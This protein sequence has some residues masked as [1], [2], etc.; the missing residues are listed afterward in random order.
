MTGERFAKIPLRAARMSELAASDYR[1]LIVIA[2]HANRGEAFPS[3]A[4]IAELAGI[5]RRNAPARIKKLEHAGLI[6]R[7]RRIDDQGDY[8]STLYQ[9]VLQGGDIRGDD[10]PL[11]SGEMTGCHTGGCQGVIPGDDRVSYRGML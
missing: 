4:T 2:A 5:D 10:T 1:V 8:G 7:E 9:I 3:L 11:S 6:R